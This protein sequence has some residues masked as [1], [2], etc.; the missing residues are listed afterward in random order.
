MT[1]YR[2]GLGL[3]DLGGFDEHEGYAGAFLG[4]PGTGAHLEFTSGRGSDTPTPHAE[5]LLVLYLGDAAAVHA[6]VA[7][8]G[9]A[10]VPSANPYWDDAGAVTVA[11]PDGFL[12]V[13]VPSNWE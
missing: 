6:A 10:P 12:V 8:C 13:L 9:S 1:F 5:S 11:D 2:D 7:R 4:I 3:S